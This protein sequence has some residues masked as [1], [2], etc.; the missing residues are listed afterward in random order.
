[1]ATIST[2]IF[3]T[4]GKNVN[5]MFRLFGKLHDAF[6]AGVNMVCSL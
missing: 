3:K 6:P 5:S 4:V 1:M 2:A